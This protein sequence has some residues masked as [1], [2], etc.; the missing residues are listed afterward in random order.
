MLSTD[1]LVVGSFVTSEGTPSRSLR[2][3]ARVLRAGGDVVTVAGVGNEAELFAVM[4]DVGKQLRAKLGLADNPVETTQASRAAYPKSLDAT[5][6]YS[7]G[8]AKLRLLESVAAKDQFERAAAEEPGNPMIEMGLASAWTALGYDKKAEEAA[9]RAFDGSAPLAREDRLNV[10]GRLY[11]ATKQWPKAIDV[12]RDVVGILRR[13]HRL[14]FAA[15]RRADLWRQ[16]CR[17][18]HDGRRLAP[19]ACGGERRARG[20]R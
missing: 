12:Y 14:R 17:C 1:D 15:G 4:A 3:D 6:L 8:I 16:G 11:E 10:E 19:R 9:K 20:S 13:Q 5:R 2:L 18:D 7:E